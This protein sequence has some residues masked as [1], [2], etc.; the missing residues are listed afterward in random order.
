M[1]IGNFGI[2]NFESMNRTVPG[3]G[4]LNP[5]NPNGRP[6]FES[7]RVFSSAVIKKPQLCL[8]T[9][10]KKTSGKRDSNPRPRPWQG[11]ALPTELFPRLK[12]VPGGGLEPPQP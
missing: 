11:R 3:G 10:V 2:E 9:E 8:K 5:H 4:G 6:N 7:G 1:L 12:T